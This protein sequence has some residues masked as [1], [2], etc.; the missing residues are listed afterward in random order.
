[1]A[2]QVDVMRVRKSVSDVNVGPACP[3]KP[4]SM[5]AG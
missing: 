4:S 3:Q 1:L 5:I 2:E